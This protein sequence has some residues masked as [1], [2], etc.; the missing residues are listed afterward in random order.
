MITRSY[1]AVIVHPSPGAL[2]SAAILAAS[3]L[4][5]LVIERPEDTSEPGR[6]RF[7]NH[8]RIL[9]GL[10]GGKW[11]PQ[12]L[13]EIQ[14]HPRDIKT[15]RRSAP[16]FQVVDPHHRVD[17]HFDG[18]QFI[19]DLA[20]EFGRERALAANNLL[21]RLEEA[22]ERHVESIGTSLSEQ[23]SVGLLGRIGLSKISWTEPRESSEYA[24]SLRQ[25]AEEEGVDDELLRFVTAPLALLSGAS[26]PLAEV[27]LGRVG[28]VLMSA[29][30]GI[31][32]DPENP[33]AFDT[34]MRKRVEGIKV[35]ITSDDQPQEFGVGWGRLKE[36]RFAGRQQPVRAESLITGDDPSLLSQW[37][38]GAAADEYSAA[39][40]DLVPTHF[41]HSLRLGIA[42]GVVPEGMCDHVFLLAEPDS[43]GPDCMLLSLTP[44]GSRAAPEGCRAL[45]VSC[46]LPLELAEDNRGLDEASKRML[47]RVKALVPYLQDYIEVIHIPRT[48]SRS[49]ANPFPVDPRPVAF[50]TPEGSRRNALLALPHR[51]VFYCGRG[52]LPYL[53]LDGEVIAGMAVAR[54][55]A[56]VIRKGR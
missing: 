18:G 4:Q 5:V 46:R 29:L 56:Q 17:V 21:A 12:A 11:L 26:D 1:D 19:D 52:A 31:Y 34:L 2:A 35:D 27:G 47:E 37:L 33:D 50:A 23:T 41:L 13:R 44:E 20:R 42:D 22:A 30:D 55:A 48:G 7:P 51:N 32:Q 40:L 43:D 3:G 39:G 9:A 25:V 45:T 28:I 10:G 6:Y 36:I 15:M 53:G 14:V 38:D 49:E 54:L 8:R 24:V 16:L